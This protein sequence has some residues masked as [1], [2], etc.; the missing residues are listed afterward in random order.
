[1]AAL[2]VDEGIGRDLVQAL[3]IQG[4]SALHVIDIGLKGAHDVVVF[5]EAQRRGLSVF[6]R[7]RDDSVFAATCWRTWG[8][9]DHQGVIAPHE[10]SQPSRADL[11]TALLRY[12]ADTSSFV[13]FIELFQGR[14]GG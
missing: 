11:Y 8:L 1:M 12:C 6:T 3:V 5:L 4:Y 14:R 2:L 10:G 9:G 7:N 13:N